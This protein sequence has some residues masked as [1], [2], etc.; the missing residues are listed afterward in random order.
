M[1]AF[2]AERFCQACRR[3]LPLS[4]FSRSQKKYYPECK[5]CRA[6]LDA[7]AKRRQLGKKHDAFFK[8]L[9]LQIK[10]KKLNVPHVSEVGAGILEQ[11]GSLEEF[12]RRWYEQI[13]K[14]PDG[15]K[16]KL[17]G[18]RAF[19]QIFHDSTLN[20]ESAPDISDM[21]DDELAAELQSLFVSNLE[22]MATKAGFKIYKDEE[23]GEG[24]A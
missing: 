24:V 14:A 6:I 23:G 12:C 8:Q 1:E 18:Y 17:D 20:R 19:Y 13:D 16:T 21:T 5:E 15:S 22:E 7:E 3:T 2:G 10:G 11:F 9:A 4:A